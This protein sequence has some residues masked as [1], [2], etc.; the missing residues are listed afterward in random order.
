M[1][2]R[3]S[4]GTVRRDNPDRLGSPHGALVRPKSRDM[5][6]Q[7]VFWTKYLLLNTEEDG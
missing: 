6:I 7:L 1:A 2:S 5:S 4:G 3:F